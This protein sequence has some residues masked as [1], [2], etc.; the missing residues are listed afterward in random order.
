VQEEGYTGCAGRK[1]MLNEVETAKIGEKG[2]G[3]K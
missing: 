3:R 1:I 2:V